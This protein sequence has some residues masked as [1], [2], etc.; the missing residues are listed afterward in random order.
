MNHL[1]VFL[2]SMLIFA[3]QVHAKTC[4]F[5]TPEILKDQNV[6]EGQYFTVL[7]DY[8]PHVLGHL[9][10]IPKRHIVKAHELSKDEWCE[11]ADIMPKIVK[12]FSEFLKTDDY[13]IL[14]K[15]GHNAFQHVP[16]VHFHLYPVHS[17]TWS[18]ILD[19]KQDRL[20]RE[21]LAQQVTLFR[22]YFN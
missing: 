2:L 20:S 12:V 22:G 3:T 11:L 6:F 21:N 7:L 8:E 4:T 19:G 10:V 18:D 14:E 17:E 16:H 15:N 13:I 9:L 1:T 5:C